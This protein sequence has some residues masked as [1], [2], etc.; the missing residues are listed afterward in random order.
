MCTFNECTSQPQL[1]CWPFPALQ[2]VPSCLL[3]RVCSLTPASGHHWSAFYCCRFVLRVLKF[4]I[5]GNMQCVLVDVWLPF[6]LMVLLKF[7]PVVGGNNLFLFSRCSGHLLLLLSDQHDV[8]NKSIHVMSY[9]ISRWSR[10]LWTTLQQRTGELIEPWDKTVNE[11]S[12]LSCF[13]SSFLIRM[14]R[15]HLLNQWPHTTHLRSGEHLR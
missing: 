12:Y 10:S 7:I 1:R 4:Y 14:E 5:N 9:V 15:T 11:Y 6:L 2:K 3:Q 13:W 8:T